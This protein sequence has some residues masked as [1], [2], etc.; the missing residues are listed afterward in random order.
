MPY[1]TL[2]AVRLN[3]RIDGDANARALLLSNSLGTALEMWEPQMPVLSS[4]FR[5]IRYDSRGH[6]RSEAPRGPYTI[7]DFGRDAVGL[8]D[9]LKIE[10]AHF[11]GLSLGGAVGLWLGVHAAERIGRLVVANT[12]AKIGT[13][14]AWNARIAAVERDG[15]ASVAKAVLGRWL[16]PAML[17]Q[18][19]PIVTALR[20]TFESTSSS[21][22]AASCAAVRDLDLRRVIHRIHAPTLVIAGTEDHVTTQDDAR[23]IADEIRGARVVE[24]QAA[25]LSN[26]QASAAFTQ[27]VVEFLN[28]RR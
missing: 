22:Y 27:A 17:E 20:R 9:A 21:G 12:G 11:C 7:D 14:D 23:A 19:T 18:P 10:R 24:L 13:V 16:P 3:Y 1:A 5:V 25:H 6:G 28:E 26:I 4:R 2:P 15:T 8:L